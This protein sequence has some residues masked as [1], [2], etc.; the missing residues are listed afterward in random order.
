MLKIGE[1]LSE[2]A[3]KDSKSFLFKKHWFQLNFEWPTIAMK[4]EETELSFQEFLRRSRLSLW[5]DQHSSLYLDLNGNRK[6]FQPNVEIFFNELFCD[7]KDVCEKH[8]TILQNTQLT[9]K[10]L[11]P[12]ETTRF[13]SYFN[14]HPVDSNM[15]VQHPDLIAIL[16]PHQIT[17][18]Q[19]LLY[20]ETANGDFIEERVEPIRSRYCQN[21]FYLN[22]S[23]LMIH[24]IKPQNCL[25]PSGGILADEMG[26]GK[27]VMMLTLFLLNPNLNVKNRMPKI[28]DEYNRPLKTFLPNFKCICSCRKKGKLI[29]CLECG[30]SSHFRCV[31]KMSCPTTIANYLCP[32]CW[33]HQDSLDCRTTLIVTPNAII[34]QW[35]SEIET[36]ISKFL[37]ILIYRRHSKKY[38]SPLDLVQYDFVIVDYSTLRSEVYF[39]KENKCSMNRRN[40]A[41]SMRPMSPF[42]RVNWWRIC[43]DE[44]QMVSSKFT[45]TYEMINQLNCVN[46]WAVSGTP[47][48]KSIDDLLVH[49]NL[50]DLAPL[51]DGHN[52]E[53]LAYEY[54]TGASNTLVEYLQK[55][56][57]RNSKDQLKSYLN[58]PENKEEVHFVSFNN[59][60]RFY[61]NEQ[62]EK[63]TERFFREAQFL[64]S[65]SVKDIE[66]HRFVKLITPLKLL[67]QSCT[68]PVIKNT[69]DPTYKHKIVGPKELSEHLITTNEMACKVQLRTVVT[70]YNGLA[71]LYLLKNQT[72]DAINVY[73][74]V[75]SLS[76]QYSDKIS[77]DKLQAIH[78][79]YNMIQAYKTDS[80]QEE[81]V[82][83]HQDY[84]DKMNAMISTYLQEKSK[85]FD[86]AK[87]AFQEVQLEIKQKC[88]EIN[89][90]DLKQNVADSLDWLENDRNTLLNDINIEISKEPKYDP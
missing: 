11:T 86:L 76:N 18:V 21:T 12:E 13:L 28:L 8:P 64:R 73:K 78:A 67:R 3:V 74:H 75:D 87:K 49:M 24:D 4:M 81:D 23:S 90:K 71:G 38:I 77:V 42:T 52:F 85:P 70:N 72:K 10:E 5:Y 84:R 56:M 27:T 31:A 36:H 19:W 30:T 66:R 83:Q 26:L 48:H 51:S 50:F 57:W 41:K 89:I 29:T 88:K 45:K 82:I 1:K 7:F 43:M 44:A 58:I 16:E 32:E 79:L 80:E 34:D 46:K 20:K 22:L 61:Y 63:H 60:M 40:E 9:D 33:Q 59:S 53:R 14:N 65:T 17:A 37:N 15:R 69:K 62:R 68:C 2:N 39:N 54:R 6:G 25:L 35:K 47:I 55:I